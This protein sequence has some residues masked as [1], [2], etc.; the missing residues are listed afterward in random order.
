M[1]KHANPTSV[2]R[3]YKPHLT[4]YQH[5]VE[6]FQW[7]QVWRELDGLPNDGGLNL[8]YEAVDRHALTERKNNIA[9]QWLG[10]TEEQS[11]TY[12]QL[13]HQ[14]AQ[15]AN[16]LDALEIQEG[17]VVSTLTGRIP[18]LYIT[19]LGTLKHQSVYS[20]LFSI[21]G[22]QPIY[23]RLS[24]GETKVLVTTQEL[25]QKKVVALLNRLDDLK[26]VLITDIEEDRNERV[27]SLPALM[28]AAE[29]TY[30][31]QPT[32]PETVGLLHFTSGTT[33]MPKGV[34]HVHQAALTHYITGK[35]VL[36]FHPE[37]RFWCTADP[38]W[39]TGTSYGILAPLMHGITN[40]VVEAE[41]DARRWYEILEEQRITVWYTAPTAIRRLMRMD[42]DVRSEYNLD[43]LRLIH[44]VGEPLNPEAIRWGE[45]TLGMPILDNWWQT[46]TGGIMIANY[47][48]L[49]IKHGSMGKPLPGIQAAVVRKINSGQQVEVVSTPDEQGEL[50][51]KKGWPSMFRGYLN[52]EKRY[53]ECFKGEWYLTGDLARFD[54]DGYFWFIGR[55]DD[56]IKTAGHMVGPFEVENVLME[57]SAV[58]EAAVVGKPDQVMGELV[59]AF[60]TLKSN[61]AADEELALEIKGFARERLGPAVAPREITFLDELPKTR[62]GKIM[63]RQLREQVREQQK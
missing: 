12:Q 3:T 25:F 53:R 10:L 54:E 62:S 28:A 45:Q 31:I 4:N 51:L 14:T 55:A 58:A 60:V 63:R 30:E 40:V 36:D 21:Y 29:S 6:H 44:S 23:Q 13:M 11:I 24:Q 5:I 22:P 9:I 50:A 47:P 43:P 8:A 20:P 33:G 18:E 35:Y 61:Y 46:E 56:I 41:F 7:E 16:V 17:E 27:R 49:P 39:V 15:F 26:Y 59:T 42:I 38:G 19:A 2:T 37:D 1:S 57:H 34:L 48:T 32:N 52:D